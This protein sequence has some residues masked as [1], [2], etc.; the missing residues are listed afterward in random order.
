MREIKFRAYDIQNERMVNDPY[1]FEPASLPYETDVSPWVFYEDW[2]DV[3]DGIRRSCHVMQ[4][5]GLND[6]YEGDVLTDHFTDIDSIIR[7]GFSMK[8]GT[9][10]FYLENRKHPNLHYVFDNIMDGYSLLG[11]IYEH[12][13]LLTP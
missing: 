5:T 4:Y 6:W 2:Q 13:N 11:N 3:D 9:I 10:G 12:P 8:T 7:F 1:R